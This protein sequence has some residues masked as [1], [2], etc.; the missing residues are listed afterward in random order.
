MSEADSAAAGA[1]EMKTVHVAKSFKVIVDLGAGPVPYEVPAGVQSVPA[2]VADHWYAAAHL[3]NGGFGTPE[4]ARGARDAADNA[5]VQA[6]DMFKT[7]EGLEKAATDAEEA[8]GQVPSAPAFERLGWT[9]LGQEIVEDV[10]SEIAAGDSSIA[11]GS[12]T[13]AEGAAGSD[14][15]GGDDSVSNAGDPTL[16]GAA[17]D[18]SV[19]ASGD[20]T[21]LSG[22]GDDSI[23]G[24][25]DSSIAGGGAADTAGHPGDRDHDGRAHEGRSKTKLK[26]EIRALGGEPVSGTAGDLERQL[27][28]LLAKKGA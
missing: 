5:F 15:V 11:G 14:S 27:A 8:A 26:A 22:Q 13:L 4:Y 25:G 1:P 24:A 7:Y 28:D 3:A 9:F 19:S 21:I 10:A 18:D 12:D 16:S 2:S 17:G 6:R 20:S 23:G